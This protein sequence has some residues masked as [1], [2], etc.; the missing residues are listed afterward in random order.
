MAGVQTSPDAPAVRISGT[1]SLER[2]DFPGKSV[3][4]HILV[5]LTMSKNRN[6]F[7]ILKVKC[8][9]DLFSFLNPQNSGADEGE[10]A[11]M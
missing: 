11:I 2:N 10:F 6:L 1:A 8:W 3:G 7:V 9:S 5:F 4:G